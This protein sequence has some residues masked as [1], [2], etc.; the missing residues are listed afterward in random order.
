MLAALI[1]DRLTKKAHDIYMKDMNYYKVGVVVGGDVGGEGDSNIIIRVT[2]RTPIF[3]FGHYI[4][5]L[6]SHSFFLY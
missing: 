4:F 5:L 6:S 2:N 1:R 3:V